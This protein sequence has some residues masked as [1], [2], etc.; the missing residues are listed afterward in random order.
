MTLEQLAEQLKEDILLHY[1]EGDKLPSERALAQQFNSTQSKIHRALAILIEQKLLYTRV[2]NG[3]FFAK[4]PN[5]STDFTVKDT[6]YS[7][8]KDFYIPYQA[9]L[10]VRIF[11]MGNYE[12]K[13]YWEKIFHLFM[14]KYP[15]IRIV[16]EFTE[17]DKPADVIIEGLHTICLKQQYF[18]PFTENNLKNIGFSYSDIADN[19]KTLMNVDGTVYL[20]PILR[21]S[22]TLFANS[23]LLEQYHIDPALLLGEANVFKNAAELEK[24]K[25]IPVICYRNYHWHG[26]NY[27]FRIYEK[28]GVCE[29][30]VPLL[31]QLFTDI[32][33]FLTPKNFNMQHRTKLFSHGKMVALHSHY[34]QMVHKPDFPMIELNPCKKNGFNPESILC[35]AVNKDSKYTF[36]GKLFAAFLCTESVQQILAEAFPRW[37]PINK[38]TL[39]GLG[40]KGEDILDLR[41]Y[42]SFFSKKVFFHIGPLINVLLARYCMKLQSFDEILD[43][44]Q[45]KCRK[46][47]L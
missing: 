45:K 20:L 27:G 40:R 46:D 12:E 33:H 17:P 43:T 32:G 4:R 7:A 37:T 25:N 31:K 2:G 14:E 8:E 21:I 38:K 44:L 3:T 34:P 18:D 11:L 47:D 6:F 28:N 39:K 19:C 10:R 9:T 24:E 1:K 23:T 22:S 42:Y 35:A 13:I 16:P 15:Y 26:C 29:L 30:D 5:T 36:E 41:S